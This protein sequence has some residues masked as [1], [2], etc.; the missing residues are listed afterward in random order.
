MTEL[1]TIRDD[2][3]SEPNA[4]TSLMRLM[5]SRCKACGEAFLGAPE[6]CAN[7]Q[8]EEFDPIPLSR[9]GRLFSYTVVRNQPPGDYKGAVNP[10]VPYP[11][12]LVELSE[13]LRILCRIDAE[14]D[15]L[16][17]D[18]PLTLS[19]HPY[20]QDQEGNTVLSYSYA[21]QGAR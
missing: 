9:E 14:I 5:G 7:C 15:A 18:M 1:R 13:G 11:V 10:F 19:V 6:G 17:I 16:K 21:A 8:S 3:F 4:D 2:F 12:G 20:Y